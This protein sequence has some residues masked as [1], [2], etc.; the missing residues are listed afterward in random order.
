MRSIA[1]LSLL[2]ANC[3]L[4]DATVAQAPNDELD[5]D[6]R[7]GNYRETILTYAGPNGKKYLTRAP[8]GL[9]IT[10][11]AQGKPVPQVG[12]A[13][14]LAVHGDFQITI[15]YEILNADKPDFGY[16][17]GV[18]LQIVAATQAKDSAT[19]A[20]RVHPQKGE[21]FATNRSFQGQNGDDN[22]SVKMFPTTGK[23]GQLRLMRKGSA[24][25]F[26]A[27][28]VNTEDFKELREVEFVDQPLKVV[29]VMGDTGNFPGALD[30]RIERLHIRCSELSSA[31]PA[32]ANTQV[33]VWIALVGVCFIIA[34]A[35]IV[36]RAVRKRP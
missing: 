20:R 3:L 23:R 5:L 33:G 12:I 1:F 10:I 34:A 21:V 29:R 14:K 2:A 17:M 9:K 19:V 25:T 7:G 16:G 13:S 31:S 32:A 4:T 8:E 22:H 18:N 6:F 27:A 28:D 24:L 26:A 30:I 35:G 15:S 11:P 36:W